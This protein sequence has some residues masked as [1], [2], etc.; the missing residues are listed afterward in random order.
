MEW[1][2]FVRF[3][4][5]KVLL[6][7]AWAGGG[8]LVISCRIVLPVSFCRFRQDKNKTAV[9]FLRRL[10]G[11]SKT[12]QVN[13]RLWIGSHRVGRRKIVGYEALHFDHHGRSVALDLRLDVELGRFLP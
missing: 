10:L 13:C 7:F 3:A 6:V 8:F 2:A 5:T 1:K 11:L 9:A 12:V 4:K